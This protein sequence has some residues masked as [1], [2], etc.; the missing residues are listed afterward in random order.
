MEQAEGSLKFFGDIWKEGTTDIDEREAVVSRYTRQILEGLN[1]LHQEGV[2]H[3]DIK[4]AN[5][6]LKD[7]GIVKLAD[8]GVSVQKEEAT[9]KAVGSSYW[10][11]PEVIQERPATTKVD[12]WSVGCTVIEIL[13]GRPPYYNLELVSAAYHMVS[14][15][16]PPLPTKISPLC[17]SFLRKCFTKDVT[18][19]PSAQ[20]LLNDPFILKYNSPNTVVTSAKEEPK[21]VTTLT[22]KE[23]EALEE[24]NRLLRQYQEQEEDD[25][26]FDDEQGALRVNPTLIDRHQ[27]QPVFDDDF[28]DDDEDD[29][30]DDDDDDAEPINLNDV[31]TKKYGDRSTDDIQFEDIEKEFN[32]ID[33]EEHGQDTYEVDIKQLIEQLND[34]HALDKVLLSDIATTL[35]EELQT[36]QRL[37]SLIPQYHG[38]LPIVDM[39]RHADVDIQLAYLRLINAIIEANMRSNIERRRNQRLQDMY[40]A[41][42]LDF[43]ERFC[44]VG[45][46]HEIHKYAQLTFPY[47]LRKQAITTL[48]HICNDRKTLGIFVSSSGL[49]VLVDFLKF[50]EFEKEKDILL[51]TLRIFQSM[52]SPSKIRETQYPKYDFCRL[53][54]RPEINMMDILLPVM[55]LLLDDDTA[56]EL[57]HFIVELI[58]LFSKAGRAVK[59]YLSEVPTLT[60]LMNFFPK[61]SHESKLTMLQA[62]KELSSDPITIHNMESTNTV[63][64]LVSMLAQ[65]DAEAEKHALNTLHQLCRLSQ[66]IRDAAV[67]AGIIPLL[68]SILSST[69]HPFRHLAI[70]IFCD[71]AHTNEHTRQALVQ[72]NSLPFYLQLFSDGKYAYDNA[73]NSLYIILKDEAT[74]K[75]TQTFLCQR[76]HVK[77]IRTMCLQLNHTQFAQITTTLRVMIQRS[78]RLNKLLSANKFDLIVLHQLTHMGDA[79]IFVEQMQMMQYLFKHTDHPKQLATNAHTI[80]Q[81]IATNK[82]HHYPKIATN[83]A[84]KLLNAFNE[85]LKF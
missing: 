57:I 10:M 67:T 49:K 65:H 81:Q 1:Y 33:M 13:T 70:D 69:S 59:Q 9:N 37:Y 74:F 3:R 29:F 80:T 22:E 35:I 58:L 18:R 53:L 79:M 83:I 75:P 5:L 47:A 71:L 12:I 26:L 41:P 25:D 38:V 48:T 44:I 78:I 36:N 51:D 46:L 32:D 11:A 28:D 27:K 39:L 85:T 73:L 20:Q 72:S 77:R 7:G 61:L 52:F 84:T 60:A 19:R 82:A 2:I 30:I 56:N 54:A 6:L 68:Q 21:K 66:N 62:V 43:H 4:G 16:H 45:G 31:L 23:R 24:K 34:I 15:D 50:D 17:R 8:F 63:A 64:V 40:V 55:R 76:E 42:P 14:N